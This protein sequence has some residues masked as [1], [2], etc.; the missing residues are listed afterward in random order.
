MLA[1]LILFVC[2]CFT[3]Q[4]P[5]FEDVRV[6]TLTKVIFEGIQIWKLIIPVHQA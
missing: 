4:K 5:I 1:I 3:D 2:V 6:R